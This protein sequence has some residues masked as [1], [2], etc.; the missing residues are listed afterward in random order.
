MSYCGNCGYKIEEGAKFC[1]SCGAQ[2]IP[3]KGHDEPYQQPYQQPITKEHPG[4]DTLKNIILAMMALIGVGV[5]INLMTDIFS[6]IVSGAVLA[7]VYLFGFKKLDAHEYKTVQQL[8]MVV[9]ILSTVAFIITVVTYFWI[10]VMI[11]LAVMSLS[12]Y[13]WDL[14][15][16]GMM[17]T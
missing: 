13:G 7:S 14:I 10:H 6:F 16:K 3:Y 2:Q 11:N 9:G 15:K 8:L 4:H 1:Q 12:F 17:K 5:L